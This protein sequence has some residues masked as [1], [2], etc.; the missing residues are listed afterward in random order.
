MLALY[1]T[2][3]LALAG[4]LLLGLTTRFSQWLTRYGE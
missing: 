1:R 2:I 3:G 4:I